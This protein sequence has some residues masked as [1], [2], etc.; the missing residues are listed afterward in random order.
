M[1]KITGLIMTVVVSIIAVGSILMP[2]VDDAAADTKTF[3]NGKESLYYMEKISDLDDYTF[4]WEQGA[5]YV[6]INGK[7]V[8]LPA[9]PN[10]YSIICVVDSFV[11]RYV[12]TA[13]VMQLVGIGL[14][15]EGADGFTLTVND[16]NLTI[17]NGVDSTTK[18]SP[19]GYIMSTKGAPYV[20]KAPEQSAYINKDTPLVGMGVTNLEGVWNIGFS[21]TGTVDNLAVAQYSGNNYTISNIVSDYAPVDGFVDLYSIDKISFNIYNAT[22]E[23]SDVVVYNYF[24][25]PAKITVAYSE[26]RALNEYSGLVYTIPVIFIVSILALVAFSVIRRSD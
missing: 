25:V 14:T 7:V 11:L 21:I 12:D 4:R 2:I 15:L 23:Y 8:N 9:T 22:T 10:S 17:S 5:K 6:T 16:G 19:D 26:P 13:S 20:M 1:N 18:E 3:D 24:I